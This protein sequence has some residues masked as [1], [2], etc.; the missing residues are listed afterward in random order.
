[1]YPII[2]QI[3]FAKKMSKKQIA[4]SLSMTYNTFLLKLKGE[5][6][7]TL[8]EAINLKSILKTSHTIEELFDTKAKI[9]C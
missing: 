7:F 9:V 4:E 6:T 3:I 2:E 1:M 5:A 8:D